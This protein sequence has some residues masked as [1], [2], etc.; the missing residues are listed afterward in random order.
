M[1]EL[2]YIVLATRV[3]VVASVNKEVGDWSAYIDAVPGINHDIEYI[4]VV[5]HG[6]KLPEKYAEMFFPFIATEYNWR[7]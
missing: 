3:L 5:K 1:R 4:E 6:A 2:H 7:K